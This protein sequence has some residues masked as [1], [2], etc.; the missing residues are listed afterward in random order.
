M[1][2]HNSK[3]ALWVAIGTAVYLVL[4]VI[5]FV[6]DIG[7]PFSALFFPAFF[8]LI[9]P[10]PLLRTFGLADHHWLLS[11]PTNTGF[12]FLIVTYAILAYF[13]TSYIERVRQTRNDIPQ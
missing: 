8:M 12:F 5:T 7:L 3:M 11:F 1:K 2:K 9:V 4:A 10:T 13:L 6:L